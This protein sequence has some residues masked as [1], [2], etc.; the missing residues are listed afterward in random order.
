MFKTFVFAA[1]VA[2]SCLGAIL[3][4]ASPAVADIPSDE[5]SLNCLEAFL[6]QLASRSLDVG[7]AGVQASAILLLLQPSPAAG[8]SAFSR[9]RAFVDS[10]A[11]RLPE[12]MNAHSRSRSSALK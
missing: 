11:E 7:H 10:C 4:V 8:T 2:I 6:H 12:R 9:M 5:M 3:T 1:F